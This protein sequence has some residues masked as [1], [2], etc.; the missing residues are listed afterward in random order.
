MYNSDQVSEVVLHLPVD[1][2]IVDSAIRSIHAASQREDNLEG[3]VHCQPS[4]LQMPFLFFIMT[5]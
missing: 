1:V 5:L 4:L 2:L 3:L